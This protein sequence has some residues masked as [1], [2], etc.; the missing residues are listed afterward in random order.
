MEKNKPESFASL[1]KLAKKR[2]AKRKPLPA[3][4]LT[5]EHPEGPSGEL[6][7]RG[8]N[9]EKTVRRWNRILD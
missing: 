6:N 4:H 5:E 9:R 7:P 1:Q 3:G 8:S 2:A